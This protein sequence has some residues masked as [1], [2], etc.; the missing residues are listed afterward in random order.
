MTSPFSF[1]CFLIKSQSGFMTD[2]GFF[3]PLVVG[4]ESFVMQIN[5]RLMDILLCAG[6]VPTWFDHASIL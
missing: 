5:E 1:M 6:L 2:E 4:C 3:E